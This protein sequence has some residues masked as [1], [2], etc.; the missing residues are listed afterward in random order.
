MTIRPLLRLI[1]PINKAKN[2]KDTQHFHIQLHFKVNMCVQYK[3]VPTCFIILSF[4]FNI[5][6]DSYI[7]LLSV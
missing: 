1:E 7:L 2:A 4:S 3:S 6:I 5:H